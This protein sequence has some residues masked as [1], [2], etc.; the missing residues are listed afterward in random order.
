MA[1]CHLLVSDSYLHCDVLSC[2]KKI[3]IGMFSNF[4]VLL[5]VVSAAILG[6]YGQLIV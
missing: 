2:D 3:A 4:Q 5:L 6:S 1:T